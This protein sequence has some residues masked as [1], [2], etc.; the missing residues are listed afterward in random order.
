MY[1]RYVC[2][3]CV[4]VIVCIYDMCLCVYVMCVCVC[5]C[6]YMYMLMCVYLRMCDICVYAMYANTVCAHVLCE[7]VTYICIDVGYVHVYVAKYCQKQE[8]S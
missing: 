5:V 7:N 6:M 4:Y 2:T 3:V 1:V 8:D